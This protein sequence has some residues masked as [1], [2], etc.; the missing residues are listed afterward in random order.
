MK[1]FLTLHGARAAFEDHISEGDIISVLSDGDIIEDYPD[2]YP[3]PS[4]L[5]LGWIDSRPLHVVAAHRPRTGEEVIITTYEPDP[6]TWSKD[7]RR[8]L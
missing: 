6:D 4:R 8:R 1:I 7:F 2:D 3:L 5:M